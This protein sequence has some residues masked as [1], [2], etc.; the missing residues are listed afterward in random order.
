[1]EFS[2]DVPLVRDILGREYAQARDE[3]R[4]WGVLRA[5]ESSRQR[6]D[7]RIAAAPDA[8]TLACRAGCMWCC[9]FPVDVRVKAYEL[10]CALDA[11]LSDPGARARFESGLK[12]FTGLSG[13]EVSAEFDDLEP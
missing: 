7:A 13:E 6:H 5:L 9:Y 1:M 11:A 8:G 3:I 2:L 4:D 12:P 10:N